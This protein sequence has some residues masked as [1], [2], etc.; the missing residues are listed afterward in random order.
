MIPSFTTSVPP[1]IPSSVSSET[2]F[3]RV[4]KVGKMDS[5][6]VDSSKVAGTATLVAGVVNITIPGI[7]S[8]DLVF[9]TLKSINASPALGAQYSV[10]FTAAVGVTPAYITITSR[11][12][13]ATVAT[14]DVS[15]I[16]YLIVKPYPALA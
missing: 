10:V 14:T 15:I 4:L 11:T 2:T 13:T 5:L 9:V 12:I 3:S 1:R 7:Q 8:T 6:S 16:Q